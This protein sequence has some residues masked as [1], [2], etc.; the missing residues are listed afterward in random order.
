MPVSWQI[1]GQTHALASGWIMGV[2]NVTP[3]SF[4]DGGRFLDA[5][6]AVDHGLQLVADG[7]E[8]LDVGG[9]ST[10]PGADSVSLEEEW[11]RVV[12]VIAALRPQTKALVSVD[13]RKAEVARAAIEAGADI[14]NDVSGLRDPA[15]IE[16]AAQCDAGVIMMHMQGTPGTMQQQPRYDDVVAEVAAFFGRRL[17][18]LEAAGI[19]RSRIALDPGIGFGKTLEHNIQLLRQLAGLRVDGRPLVV[20]VSRKSFIA[21]LLDDPAMDKRRWP[22]VALTAW[23]RESGGDVFR[24]HDVKEN[25]DALRMIGAIAG[26]LTAK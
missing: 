10:R 3:D 24:V 12:P 22:T 5:G 14:I 15:M 19:S 13:T 6:R 11:R 16:V 2:L 21:R 20:G 26:G 1:H 7:A 23:L 9:E 4:S 25:A 8:I 18:Q 17:D